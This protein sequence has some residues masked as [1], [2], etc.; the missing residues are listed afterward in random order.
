MK[1]NLLILSLFGVF[2]SCAT[3]HFTISGKVQAGAG[4]EMGF[5]GLILP[6]V[7]N[8]PPERPSIAIGGTKSIKH[9][10]VKP[11]IQPPNASLPEL[12]PTSEGVVRTA[13]SYLGTP[14]KYGGTSAKSGMDCSGFV[15]TSFLQH[16]ITLNRS[17]YE[18]ANQ[19]TE[20]SLRSVKKGDLLFFK[21]T[22]KGRISHVGIVI[23]D[24]PEVRFVHS[25]TKRGV[26]INSMK[27]PYWQRTYI[28]ST[29]V[30][31]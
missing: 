10:S 8:R 2:V 11:I 18:M 22:P 30:I 4:A 1:A 25:A 29:R 13:L 7:V 27:E 6:P 31:N 12:L 3:P 15:Y 16:N 21:T 28:K 23:E 24:E 26:V 17:S 20:I 19:G 9:P 14:Y 5:S